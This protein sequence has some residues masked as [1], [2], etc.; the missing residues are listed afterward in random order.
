MDSPET[1][2]FSLLCKHPMCFR[3]AHAKGYC[4][5]HWRRK[6]NGRDMN[7]NLPPPKNLTD[8]EIALWFYK[9]RTQVLYGTL[10]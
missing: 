1:G 4:L 6:S 5:P 10:I 7:K 8:E 2:T 3:K 9:N